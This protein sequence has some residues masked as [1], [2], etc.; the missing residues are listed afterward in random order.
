M[1]STAFQRLLESMDKLSMAQ[2]ERL[3]EALKAARSRRAGLDALAHLGRKRRRASRHPHIGPR[4][5]GH[6]PLTRT[7]PIN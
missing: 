7:A 5:T 3:G 2:I 4:K 6:Q 1:R